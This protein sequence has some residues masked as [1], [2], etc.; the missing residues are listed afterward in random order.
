MA[1]GDGHWGPSVE[2]LGDSGSAY[3]RASLLG[4]GD[5]KRSVVKDERFDD[6]NRRPLLPHA[7]GGDHWTCS[8]DDTTQGQFA[9]RATAAI[10]LSVN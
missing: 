8:H 3:R 1:A 9:A 5:E 2:Y 10:R 4:A 7:P 6:S